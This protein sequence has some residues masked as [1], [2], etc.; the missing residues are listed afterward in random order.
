M[1]NNNTLYDYLFKDF[2]ET[3]PANLIMSFYKY[4]EGGQDRAKIWINWVCPTCQN[5]IDLPDPFKNAVGHCPHCNAHLQ[6]D[7]SK[8]RSSVA[9]H[10]NLPVSQIFFIANRTKA[11]PFMEDYTRATYR[12]AL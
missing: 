6:Y 9:N 8:R 11:K 12:H 7:W 2:Q 10:V 3:L 5:Q 4:Y 1:K